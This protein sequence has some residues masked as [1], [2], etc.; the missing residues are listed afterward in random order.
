MN[1]KYVN[2]YHIILFLQAV[3][4]IVLSKHLI[5]KKIKSVSI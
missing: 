1:M 5:T 2:P 3:A 4:D